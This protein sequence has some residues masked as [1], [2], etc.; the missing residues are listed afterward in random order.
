[1]EKI[2]AFIGFGLGVF[3]IVASC[4]AISLALLVQDAR[5]LININKQQIT[6]TLKNINDASAEVKTSAI[7]VRESSQAQRDLFTN[8]KTLDGIAL[9]LRQ[10][11]DLARTVD[12]VNIGLDKINN[13]AIPQAVY[14]MSSAQQMFEEGRE[15]IDS[16]GNKAATVLDTTDENLQQLHELLAD[17]NVKKALQ[18]IAETTNNTSLAAFHVQVTAQEIQSAIPELIKSFQ[19]VANNAD[20]SSEEVK[21]FLT[22]LNKPLTKK[23]KVFRFLTEAVIK[24]SPAL[25]RR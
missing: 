21:I 22:G 14:T 25:L 15:K 5:D 9:L 8:K 19:A 16:L 11:N 23:Q 6:S 7:A 10:G 1:M 24:S 2:K 13:L 20:Q 12:K 17:P 18:G 4:V 3:L